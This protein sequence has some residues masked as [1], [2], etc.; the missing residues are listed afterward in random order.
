LLLFSTVTLLP[1][2]SFVVLPTSEFA[3][4]ITPLTPVAPSPKVT[5]PASI[6]APLS[7]WELATM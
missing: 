1:T 2:E 7:H 4:E 3:V 5:A 6:A